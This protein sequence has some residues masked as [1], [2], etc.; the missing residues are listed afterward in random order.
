MP[1]VV[2]II[3]DSRQSRTL[4][5]LL[6]A[7]AL[8]L[9]TLPVLAQQNYLGFDKNLYPGDDLLPA[10]R[11]TFAYSGYWLNNPPGMTTN[12]W[13]GRRA[14]LHRAGFGFL[15]LFDGRLDAQLKGQDPAVLGKS[16]AIAAA[17]AAKREGFPLHAIIFLDQEEGGRLLPEQAAYLAAWFKQLAASGYRPGVYCSGIPG[18]SGKDRISTAEDVAQ[19]SPTV[20]LWVANDRCPPAPGCVMHPPMPSQSGTANVLVWQFAQSPRRSFAN[21][22]KETY[23]PDDNC[24]A[25]NLQHSDRTFVDLN[26][27]RSADPSMGR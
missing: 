7:A 19:D 3:T 20:K 22:C 24:Y 25:P 10:L 4:R 23:A 27:S 13:A 21:T 8:F 26:T 9:L 18:G 15:I 2:K 11:K 1:S 6:L 14:A 17:A 16:D 5:K 12:P